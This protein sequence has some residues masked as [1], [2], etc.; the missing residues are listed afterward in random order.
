MIYTEFIK[1]LRSKN[2]ILF[3]H[4]YRLAFNNINTYMIFPSNNIMVGGGDRIINYDD[5]TLKNII[6]TALSP[7]PRNLYWFVN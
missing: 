5:M 4:D 1:Y 7:E 6:N 2:I 3:D